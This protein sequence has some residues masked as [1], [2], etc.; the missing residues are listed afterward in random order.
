MTTAA[1]HTTH[2]LRHYFADISKAA[3]TFAA[4]LFAAQQRQF[5]AQEVATRP[6]VSERARARAH[7][8]LIRMANDYQQL[9]P[10]LAAELRQLASRG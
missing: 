4:A 2:S 9:Q 7:M 8:K 10:N 1:I 6:A 3:R 5:V